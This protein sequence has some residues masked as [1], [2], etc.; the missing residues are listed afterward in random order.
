MFKE[1]S[2]FFKKNW[3]ILLILLLGLFLRSYRYPQFPIA[4]ETA[5]ETAW[6]MLGASIIQTGQPISW[7]HFEAYQDHVVKQL[8]IKHEGQDVIFNLVGPVLDHPP[9][10]SLIPGFFHTLKN[11]WDQIP[12]IKL[13]RLPM[14][15]I[16]TLNLWL[17]YLVAGK[18]FAKKKIAHLAALIYAI[19][20][21]F[22]F[23]SRLVV[24]ENL[25]VT[26]M[27][28]SIYLIKSKIKKK[29]LFLVVVSIA[30][31]FTKVSGLVIPLGV[32]LYGW[33]NREKLVLKSG[34]IG[35]FLGEL[36]YLLY[37]ALLNWQLFLEVNLSQAGRDLGLSTLI[38]RLFLHPAIVEKFFFDGW[39]IL[40]LLAMIAL[41]L[42]KPKKYL[43]IKIYSVLWL[44]FIAATVGEQTLHGWYDYP[45]YPLLAL[46]AAW[47]IYYLL[48]QKMYWLIW[49]SWLIILPT[50]RLAL[51]FSNQYTEISNLTMRGIMGLG[52][53]P[54]GLALIK[55]DKLAQK[56]I[57]LL[58][59]VLL[60]AGIVIIVKINP[61]AYWEMD[62][63]FYLR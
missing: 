56:S 30:A 50:T 14:I 23:S 16:G 54:L 34:L 27:L 25:L 55:R 29:N 18:I 57:S 51:I 26:W 11:S 20:P 5:D 17:V 41:F 4:G 45:L 53:L 39:L 60:I 61:R 33:Q 44:A 58:G 6:T 63:F 3:L 22:V 21:T 19:M 24:A 10:F 8:V 37:G 15:L 36:S 2:I 59:L 32:I 28:L 43:I 12:S 35:L 40:G 31:I 13:I 47:F 9:L 1:L 7:S 62:Q 46:S 38:N 49:L 48:T 52:A 42:V